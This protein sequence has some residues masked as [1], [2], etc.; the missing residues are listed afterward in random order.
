MSDVKTDQTA[1]ELAEAALEDPSVHT[2][3]GLALA[4]RLRALERAER[5]RPGIHQSLQRAVADRLRA[6]QR[7][8]RRH[9]KR[10]PR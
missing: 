6:L 10:M 1:D 3:A 9:P 7:A 8:E 2:D 5:S 4:R